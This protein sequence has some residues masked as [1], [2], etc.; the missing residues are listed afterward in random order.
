MTGTQMSVLAGRVW[1][2]FDSRDDE[3]MSVGAD[4]VVAVT[5]GQSTESFDLD[6]S[7]PAAVLAATLADRFQT[8]LMEA[9]RTV[10]P[11]CPRHVGEH[12]LVSAVVDGRAVWI[13]PQDDS[14]VA[15]ILGEG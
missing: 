7:Q 11:A 2:G 13:C 10:L 14:V 3:K 5:V 9:R 15:A 4:D 6:D 8:I 12:P 1:S